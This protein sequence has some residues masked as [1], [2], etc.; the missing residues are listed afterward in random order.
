[1]L[2][3]INPGGWNRPETGAIHNPGHVSSREITLDSSLSARLRIGA[4]LLASCLAGACSSS[5]NSDDDRPGSSPDPDTGSV[6]AEPSG[7]DTPDSAEESGGTEDQPALRLKSLSGRADTISGGDALVEIQ[8]PV[9]TD[10][11]TLAVTLNARDVTDRFASAGTVPVGQGD[12]LAGLIVGLQV[13]GNQVR[14]SAGGVASATLDLVNHPGT[15]PHTGA[16]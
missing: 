6:P 8:V 13:G 11:S 1:M 16:A 14:V 15:G 12:T 4:W 10:M 3:P 7:T 5:S 9:G 2:R